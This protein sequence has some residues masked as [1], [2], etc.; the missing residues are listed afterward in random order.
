MIRGLIDGFRRGRDETI[1]EWQRQPF[2]QRRRPEPEQRRAEP[3]QP[4]PEL[5]REPHWDEPDPR[6]HDAEPSNGGPTDD[7]LVI[8]L[9]AR[10]AMIA[11][12]RQLIAGLEAE[13]RARDEEREETRRLANRLADRFDETQA[14]IKEM[15]TEL[16]A[17]D[18]TIAENRQLIAEMAKNIEQQQAH[19]TELET[20]LA[21]REAEGKEYPRLIKDLADRIEQQQARIKELEEAEPAEPFSAVLML[22]GVEKGLR[23]RFHPDMHPNADETEK[24]ALTETTKLINAVYDV[25]KQR[26]T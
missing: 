8:A 12:N 1:A 23:K 14:F 2:P 13:L 21:S 22:P 26:K 11:E 18:A 10:E 20:A 19:I 6:V 4:W 16:A 7:D 24:L 5:K 3:E 17:R 25:I 15:E 9:A